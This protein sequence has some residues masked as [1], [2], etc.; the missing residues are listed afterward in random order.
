MKIGRIE[1][2]RAKSGPQ[3]IYDA[4]SPQRF[5]EP[6]QIAE[7]P[8][9]E[10][11]RLVGP[12]D[13]FIR[14]IT[15]DLPYEYKAVCALVWAGLEMSGCVQL[16]TDPFL[17]PRLYACMIGPPGTGKSASEKE[18]R[19]ALLPC[20]PQI[21]VEYSVDSGPALI[22]A[23]SEHN[24]LLLSPDELAD[25]FEKARQTPNAHNSLFGE[26]LRLYES[27][28]TG[29][30]VV[31]KNAEPIALDNVHLAIIGGATPERFDRMWTGTQGA[32]GGLQSRFVLAFSDQAAPAVK[33]PNRDEAIESARVT[34]R[35][36]GRQRAVKL[37]GDAQDLIAAWNSGGHPRMLDMAKRFALILAAADGRDQIDGDLTLRALKF[38]EHQIALFEKFMPVDSSSWVQAFENRILSFFRRH[39]QT[40]ERDVRRSI[41]PERYPG[42]YGAF[43][44]ALRGLARSGKLIAS[45]TNRMGKTLW[46]LD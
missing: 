43:E 17:Q 24:R 21:H 37:S 46:R 31:K 1:R 4:D 3:I 9:P 5:V 15:H 27:N 23:A 42:G 41:S 8:L 18:V 36:V 44:Q 7:P 19:R 13:D 38:A 33:T 39:T 40:S 22:E 32:A 34:L 6:E 25:L 16:A 26:L 10:F 29:R 35:N 30:R 14:S 2:I 20:F 12:L 11:P 45:G 28:T